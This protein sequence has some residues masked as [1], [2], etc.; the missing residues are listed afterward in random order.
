[1]WYLKISKIWLVICLLV[2]ISV[3]TKI[4]LC[5]IISGDSSTFPNHCTK[6][7]RNISLHANK[8]KMNRTISSMQKNPGGLKDIPNLQSFLLRYKKMCMHH[9]FLGRVRCIYL[10]IACQNFQNLF[11]NIFEW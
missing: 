10:S 2:L 4:T 1:M 6:I 8:E 11:Q 5:G 7:S 3:N 9:K